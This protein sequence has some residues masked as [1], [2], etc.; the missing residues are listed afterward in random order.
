MDRT[1]R[2]H[3][4]YKRLQVMTQGA[5]LRK[6]PP[7]LPGRG[8]YR[9]VMIDFPWP[10]E[11]DDPDPV[12][13]GR[14]YYP[15]PTLSIDG[16]VAF[17]ERARAIL[18]DDAVVG[19]WITN[20]HLVNGHHVPVLAALGLKPVTMRTWV[21]DRIGQGHV[22]RGQT[23]HMIIGTRGSPTIEGASISTFFHAAAG[24]LHSQKPAKAYE[25]FERLVPA[26]R[27]ASLFHVG[28]LPA[29]WDGHGDELAVLG[30][31]SGDDQHVAEAALEPK[32]LL[33]ML[34]L[35]EAGGSPALYSM[36]EPIRVLRNQIDSQKLAKKA[37]AGV[38]RSLTKRGEAKL[39][40]LREKRRQ[41]GELAELPTTI[42]DLIADYSA[43]LSRFH[44]AIVTNNQ[45]DCEREERRL[46][47]LQIKANGGDSFGMGCEDSQAEQ[48]RAGGRA[49]LGSVPLWAQPGI[50][51][52]EIDGT[53]YL[54]SIGGTVAG[55]I[56]D[57]GAYAVD[58]DKL[59]ISKTGFQSIMG[60][61]WHFAEDAKHRWPMGETV[62]AYC[63]RKLREEIAERLETG[64]GKRRR[65]PEGLSKPE[66]V[67]R[68]PAT[69]EESSYGD[70][71]EQEKLS[72]AA[73]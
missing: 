67:Y 15:Y 30:T 68:M 53:P 29:N 5:Q 46:E 18:H 27:Y 14:A 47:L 36:D 39:S 42:D 52:I 2:V 59:C 17:A 3:G 8:P 61:F 65:K 1:G 66:T 26:A 10:A 25:D 35:I 63:I 20:F 12:A 16:I 32:T 56:S 21:K 50:F 9:G 60:D 44:Q 54:I 31:S 13:S 4:P 45:T 38:L 49:E 58:P 48:L 7:P 73:E 24:K 19:V 28:E 37:G 51:R 43:T 57:F 69:W 22:L 41:Q 72:E 55:D 62:D 40:E 71:V 6:E 33:D 11:Q 64:T 34:E 70:P 23:E